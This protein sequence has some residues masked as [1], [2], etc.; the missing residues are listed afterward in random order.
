MSEGALDLL[1]MRSCST[2]KNLFAVLYGVQNLLTFARNR[3]YPFEPLLRQTLTQYKQIAWI[4]KCLER[5]C[6]I[7]DKRDQ[8]GIGT[9]ATT[10]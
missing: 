4:G 2:F 3:R 8:S 1:V 5:D 7:V 10:C 6:F 9:G